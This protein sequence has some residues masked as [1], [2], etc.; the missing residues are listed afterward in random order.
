MAKSTL[1][2]VTKTAQ[3]EF[4]KLI[5]SGKPCAKCMK[6]FP[7]MQCSHIHSIGA[8]SN[9]RFD[10]MNV[11]PMCGRCHNFWWHQEPSESWD[12]FVKNY[13]GRHQYLLKAKNKV[14]KWTMDDVLQIKEYVRNREIKKL[15]IAPELLVD[16]LNV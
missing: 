12:W 9:L 4:N 15:L 2:T 13:P 14:N 3:R 1:R 16:K 7:V 5:A 6:T 10:I 8:Y 11:L